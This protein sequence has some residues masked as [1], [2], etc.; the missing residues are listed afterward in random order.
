MGAAILA[1]AACGDG[2]AQDATDEPVPVRTATV[3]R[4]DLTTTVS[5]PGTYGPADEIALAFKIGGV[6]ARVTV[7]AGDRVEAGTLIA[8]LEPD[9]I[10][11]AVSQARAGAEKARRDLARAERLYRD[12]VAPLAA[13]EDARTAAE[14]A[15]A[16]LER[17]RFNRRHAEIRA[18][19]DGVVLERRVEGGETVG[20][21]APLVVLGTEGGPGVVRL[22][23]PD[24]DR[25]R[26]EVGDPAAVTFDALPGRSFT[27]RVSRIG[28]AASSRTGTWEAEV[29]LDRAEGL[30]PGLVGRVE[31]QRPGGAR[32]GGEV[33]LV[34]V[35]AV[36]EAGGPEAVVFVLEGAA[37]DESRIARRRP[38]RIGALHDGRIAVLGG[39][40]GVT[41][42]VTAG[43]AWLDD[44]QR[45]RVVR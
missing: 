45:V 38:V 14:V 31:I 32:E 8:A 13:L 44:G 37:D 11:A 34:P 24:R 5:A 30:V 39:L 35:D 23:L 16:E 4:G 29:A 26:V 3:E 10:A 6:V 36:L 19:A 21:G 42:V 27:G 9:E 12:S 20:A 40:E 17:A 41:Q 22:G 2:A 28:A 18:P 33:A 25:V 15:E 1:L 7:E 43:A